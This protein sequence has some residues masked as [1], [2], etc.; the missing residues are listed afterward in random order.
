MEEDLSVTRVVAV[1]TEDC[2]WAVPHCCY[3]MIGQRRRR[4]TEQV[5]KAVNDNHQRSGKDPAAAL[6]ENSMNS[7][8]SAV[9]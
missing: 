8:G 7:C 9:V 5:P 6:K 1:K 3:D 4:A 2:E